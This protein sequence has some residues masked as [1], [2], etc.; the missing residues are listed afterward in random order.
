MPKSIHK[1]ITFATVATLANLACGATAVLAAIHH[2]YLL[3]CLLLILGAWFDIVDG[4]IAK[5][6]NQATDFGAEMDSLADLVTF[7]VAPMV[8]IAT[9]YQTTWLS[10]LAVLIPLCGA[11]R[12]ARYNVNRVETKGYFIGVPIDTSCVLI[13][14]LLLLKAT[15]VVAGLA[16]TLLVGLYISTIKVP[17]I[18]K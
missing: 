16:I 9:Y 17:R 5:R 18:F 4:L 15:P 8:I 1:Y 6:R 7:G 13:P 2:D 11:L 10:A 3:S 12:L 14:A